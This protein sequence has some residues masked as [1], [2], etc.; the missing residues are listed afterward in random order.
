MFEKEAKEY[1]DSYIKSDYR[2][3]VRD[4][5][6]NGAVFGYNKASE[7]HNLRKNPDDLPQEGEIVLC[8]CLG[9]CGA[10]YPITAQMY[11]DYDDTSVHYWRPSATS[12]NRPLEEPRSVL[13]WKEIAIPINCIESAS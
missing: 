1:E 9:V 11:F 13:A 3:R 8:Y 7:W 12:G 10:S 4:T 2:E 6:R 5:W